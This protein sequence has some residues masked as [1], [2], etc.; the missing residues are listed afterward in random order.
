MQFH[1]P[2]WL[3]ASENGKRTDYYA[4]LRGEVIGINTALYAPG[5]QAVG[6]GS[7]FAIPSRLVRDRLPALRAD[8]GIGASAFLPWDPTDADLRAARAATEQLRSSDLER[9]LCVLFAAASCL[10]NP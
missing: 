2:A 7:G 5:A 4:H 10:H 1:P 9:A 6:E 3:P 8:L